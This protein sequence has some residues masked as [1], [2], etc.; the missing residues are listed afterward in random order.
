MENII[1]GCRQFSE[2]TVNKL[3]NEE[4]NIVIA[5]GDNKRR[6][7]IS[8]IF[9]AIIQVLSALCNMLQN[10]YVTVMSQN[11]FNFMYNS[12]NQVGTGLNI[13]IKLFIDEL[14]IKWKK[15]IVI[16]A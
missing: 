1:G 9:A 14:D 5:Y 2:K 7:I 4:F 10:A 11:M 6:E 12:I 3:T 13:Q 8:T 16:S 15:M